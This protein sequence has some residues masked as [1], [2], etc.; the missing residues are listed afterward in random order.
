M[1]T[2]KRGIIVR[3]GMGGFLNPPTHPEHI[4]HVQTDLRR[5]PENR[6]SMS[7]SAAAECAWLDP[8]TRRSARAKLDAWDANKPTLDAPESQEWIRQVLGYFRNCYRGVGDEPECWHAGNL[9]ITEEPRPADEHAGVRLIRKYYPDYQPT[10]EH[11][12]EAYWGTKPH[13]TARS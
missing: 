13:D 7:L 12:A 8:A 3:D 4:L 5:R 9:R 2:Y 1:R 10:P 6:S 11:F